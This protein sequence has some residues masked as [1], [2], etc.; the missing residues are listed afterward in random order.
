MAETL[1]WVS[2]TKTITVESGKQ[3][4]LCDQDWITFIQSLETL[5]KN[6]PLKSLEF[7][8]TSPGVFDYKIR[9]T[10]AGTRKWNQTLTIDNPEDPL[11]T[12]SVPDFF[13]QSEF[14]Y[15]RPVR[16]NL[17]TLTNRFSIIKIECKW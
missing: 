10:D 17:I 12:F 13:R 16:D 4:A 9:T 14:K 3:I 7:S 5:A 15:G 1:N 6:V 11:M 8:L 2:G